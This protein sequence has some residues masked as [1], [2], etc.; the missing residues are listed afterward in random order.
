MLLLALVGVALLPLLFTHIQD[1]RIL[2]KVYIEKMEDEKDTVYEDISTID[3]MKLIIESR[4]KGSSII[5]RQEQVFY[6]TEFDNEIVPRIMEELKSIQDMGVIPD[7]KLDINDLEYRSSRTTYADID[8][9]QNLVSM[10]DITFYNDICS[11]N[12]TVDT[13]TNVIYSFFIKDFERTYEVDEQE[14]IEAFGKYL[15]IEWDRGVFDYYG[16]KIYREKMGRFSYEYFYRHGYLHF[17]LL[18]ETIE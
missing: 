1:K 15:G 10:W 14:I 16:S 3:K 13:K 7:I 12:I 6:S 4:K 2:G 18:E 11:I 9:P 5:V 8:N 17:F